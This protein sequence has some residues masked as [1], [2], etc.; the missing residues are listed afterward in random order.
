M[1][2]N[3]SIV[4]ALRIAA[5][6]SGNKGI[7]KHNNMEELETL[8]RNVPAGMERVVV[9]FDGIFSMRGDYAPLGQIVALAKKYDEKFADGVLTIVDDSHGTAAYGATGRGTLEITGTW[10][11]DVIT[12]T[13]GKAFGAEGGY[14]A[15]S[16]D[17]IEIIRQKAD[18]YIYTNPVSPGAANAGLAAINIV[19]SD[20]GKALLGRVKENAEYFRRGI[21]ALGYETIPGVHPIVP[22]LIRDTAKT[23][24]TVKALYDNG[25]LATGLA[26]PVVPAGDE[27]IRIQLSAA[28]TRV[29]LDHVLESFEKAK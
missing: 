25:I 24:A 4:R 23:R 29:D 3:N 15:A 8:L 12:S 20:E 11:V 5:V 7:F 16:A 17:I 10:D 2:S 21:E 26:F 6:P 22:V 28:H 19:D 18:T 9:I 14:V 1:D 13:L 27:T